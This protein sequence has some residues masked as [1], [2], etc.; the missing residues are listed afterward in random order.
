MKMSYHEKKALKRKLR[1]A[2]EYGLKDAV[3]GS[4]K[5]RLARKAKFS[6]MSYARNGK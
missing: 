3:K 4:I 1:K 5:T 6:P 2:V